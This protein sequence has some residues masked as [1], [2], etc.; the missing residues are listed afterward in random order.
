LPALLSTASFS[1]PVGKKPLPP[2]DFVK[3]FQ[4][5]MKKKRK[6]KKAGHGMN[7]GDVTSGEKV[8]VS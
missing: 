8:A 7:A 6:M 3:V 1:K 5:T 4:L 2:R